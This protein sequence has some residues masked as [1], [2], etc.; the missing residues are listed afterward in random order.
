MNIIKGAQRPVDSIVILD[1][2]IVSP[3]IVGFFGGGGG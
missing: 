3:E 1:F 2:I